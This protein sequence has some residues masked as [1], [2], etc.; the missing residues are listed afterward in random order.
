[1]TRLGGN[2]G[3]VLPDS[4]LIKAYHRT[5]DYLLN[6]HTLM[7]ITH[8]TKPFEDVDHDVIIIRAISG[9]T[10]NDYI[11]CRIVPYRST[12]MK[13]ANA[14]QIR[15]G[16][17]NNKQLDFRFN[18]LLDEKIEAMSNKLTNLGIDYKSICETHE[19]IHTRHKRAE[20][21]PESVD[22]LTPLHKPLLIG[23]KS[24]DVIEPYYIQWNGRYVN[25]DP[26]ICTSNSRGMT[27]DLVHATWFTQ[28]KLVIVRTGEQFTTAI[29]R[30]QFYLSNNLFS[31][32]RKA[33]SA[34][35]VSYEYLCCLL[36]SKLLQRFLRLRIAPR[37][38][39]LYVETKIKHLDLLPIR[40]IDFITQVN[41]RDRQLEKAKTLYEFC[42]NNDSTEC[43][44][45][46]VKHHL[47]ANPERS[48]IVHDLLAFLAEQM[49]EM[50]KAKGEEIRDFHRWLERE[51]GVGIEALQNKTAIQSYFNLSLDG[52]LG[53]LRRNRRSIDIDLSSRNFQESLEREFT[54]SLAKLNPLLTRIEQTDALID[55]VVYQLYG[56]TD[57]E[58]AVVVG[59]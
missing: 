45:G 43:V 7:E 50:N 49:L 39:K 31:S 4:L 33:D 15:Y 53:I 56:L 59:S 18:L 20:L 19:G 35:D 27:P 24:G 58:I 13:L 22:V 36:N 48:D 16:S 55:Q 32:F 8:L 12:R 54:S 51:I 6:S 46:F 1:M 40:R 37:F 47:A 41:E 23:E 29:D 11:M 14:S 21:F 25:Y 57:E 52:L 5:R 34:L 30:E 3:M 10:P 38:G 17:W 2:F 9:K 28:P 26:T 42:L 44:L